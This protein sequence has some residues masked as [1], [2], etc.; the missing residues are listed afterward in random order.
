MLNP[1]SITITKEQNDNCTIEIEGSKSFNLLSESY[2]TKLI[3]SVVV[4]GKD[5]ST[6]YQF[7]YTEV[8]NVIRKDGTD[9]SITDNDI[10]F[11]ELNQFFFFIN[12]DSGAGGL[13]NLP[14]GN[15]VFV[16][17]LGNDG[18]GIREDYAFPFLTLNA[19][20][21]AA[22]AGDT[23]YVYGGTYNEVNQL[24][25]DGVKWHFVGKPVLNLFAARPWT[26]SGIDTLIQIEGDAIFNHLT[27]GQMVQVTALNTVV[28]FN[29]Y[30]ATGIGNQ[31]FKFDNGSGIINVKTKIEVN[32]VNRCIQLGGNA[33]YVFNI[34]DIFCN[35]TIG[36]VSN[37]INF[38]NQSPVYDGYCIF[39]CRT[40]RSDRANGATISYQYFSGQGTGIFN[41]T[42]KIHFMQTGNP[43]HSN[44]A[45]QILSGHCVVNGDIDGGEGIAINMETK[46]NVKSMTHNG[47]AYNDGTNP[48]IDFGNDTP[49]F[50]SGGNADVKLSGEYKSANDN[51]VLVR[52]E[53]NNK[54]S[55]NGKIQSLYSGIALNSGIFVGD[56]A[57]DK[58]ILESLIIIMTA[59]GTPESI[60][61]NIAKNIKV[62]NHVGTNANPNGNITNLITGTDITVDADYE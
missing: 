25:K 1:N 41:I 59:N 45:I 46:F 62:F 31:I 11:N 50:W 7:F 5:G 29:A 23:I 39:N 58:T 42:D 24:H 57:S 28:N 21:N 6:L 8:N 30:S 17:P 27:V 14:V 19:A 56:N 16:N 55:I 44:S 37:A 49:D 10:L 2:L 9:V 4:R 61:A 3:N 60:S 40:I 22:I 35:S 36:G 48:L 13:T 53:S 52:G 20:K 32:L 33:N 12:N 47:N 38:Q 51:V 54:I 15:F 43:A 18:T 26:D 34:D